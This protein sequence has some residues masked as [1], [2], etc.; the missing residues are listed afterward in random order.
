MMRWISGRGRLLLLLGLT[1]FSLGFTGHERFVELEGYFNG[2]TGADF[3]PEAQNVRA[4]LAKGTRGQILRS[5]KLPSGNYALKIRTMNGDF[6]GQEFWVYYDLERRTVKTYDKA[7]ADWR[8]RADG[9]VAETQRDVPAL[10][11]RVDAAAVARKTDRLDRVVRGTTGPDPGCAHCAGVDNVPVPRERPHRAE[12][13]PR[14]EREPRQDT[15][16]VISDRGIQI[17]PSRNMEIACY[18]MIQQNGKYGEW[19]Q[20]LASILNEERYAAQYLKAG[21]LGKFCPRFDSLSKGDKVKAWVWF[22]QSLAK[23]ESSCRLNVPHGTLTP[24]GEVLNPTEGHGLWALEKDRNLR[25]A[26]GSACDNI[27]TFSGQARC[28]VDIM[29]KTQLRRG[30]NASDSRLKYWGPTYNHRN[31]RQIMPHMQRFSACF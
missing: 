4:V 27:R 13:A 2:R 26:R 19:G 31:D 15:A 22:W 14:T 8:E 17:K 11:E 10:G 25:A 18:S 28:A 20:T 24:S 3:R 30:G 6:R 29:Y 5:A 9:P 1:S 12:T 23:E 7:P 16:P 21:A